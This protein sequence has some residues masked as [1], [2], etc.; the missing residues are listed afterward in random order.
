ML[1]SVTERTKEIGT[2]KVIGK[3]QNYT[4]TIYF[5]AIVIC[6]LDALELY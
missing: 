1:V 2:L 4:A 3:Q 6:Q 5:E